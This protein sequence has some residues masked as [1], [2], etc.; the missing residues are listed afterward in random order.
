MT[1][2]S[3]GVSVFQDLLLVFKAP[4]SG[5]KEHRGTG[6]RQE[7]PVLFSLELCDDV[8]VPTSKRNPSAAC[9]ACGSTQL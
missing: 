5:A 4:L 9:G 3:E 7:D 8:M 6:E 1:Q 2:V